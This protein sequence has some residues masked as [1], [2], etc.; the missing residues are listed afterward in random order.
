MLTQQAAEHELDDGSSTDQ[1]CTGARGPQVNDGGLLAQLLRQL[2]ALQKWQAEAASAADVRILDKQGA[3]NHRLLI[4]AQYR[5]TGPLAF[6]WLI[7]YVFT[8]VLRV[9]MLW[10]HIQATSCL[11]MP[12]R[13]AC[14]A[15]GC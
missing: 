7:A 6:C 10:R 15:L 11:H 2:T 5:T 3:S 1:A 13:S 4:H 14:E 8:F 12:V 9:L